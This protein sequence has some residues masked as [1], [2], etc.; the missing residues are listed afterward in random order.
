MVCRPVYQCGICVTEGLML[1][2]C[3][4]DYLFMLVHVEHMYQ[5]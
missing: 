4:V 3:V 5:L 2:M 1:E